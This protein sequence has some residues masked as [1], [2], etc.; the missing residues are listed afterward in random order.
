[1]TNVD[2]IRLGEL[3][4]RMGRLKTALVLRSEEAFKSVAGLSES[5]DFDDEIFLIRK[6]A[7]RIERLGFYAVQ[8]QRVLELSKESFEECEI[9]VEALAEETAADFSGSFEM[10]ENKVSNGEIGYSIAY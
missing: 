4:E 2:Y 3:S 8:L 9:Q 5:T 7:E 1:M 6:L 10:T